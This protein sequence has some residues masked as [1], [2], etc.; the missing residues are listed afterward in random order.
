[1]TSKGDVLHKAFVATILI[2]GLIGI[3]DLCIT[4][5]FI[6]RTPLVLLV[7]SMQGTLL[8]APAM[9]VMTI[10]L[11]HVSMGIFYFASHGIVKVGIVWGLFKQQ[12][13]AYPIAIAFLG[14]FSVYQIISLIAH[15]DG[16]ILFLLIVNA[17][18]VFLIAREFR[19]VRRILRAAKAQHSVV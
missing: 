2:N 14:G 1:M 3:I 19:L 4:A 11:S 15:F 6:W 12:L 13:W 17:L 8:G 7:E 18:T 10:I 5:V 9:W 16:F